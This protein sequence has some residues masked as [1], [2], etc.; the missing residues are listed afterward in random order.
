MTKKVHGLVK[1]V[2]VV[3]LSLL[4]SSGFSKG[5]GQLAPKEVAD[6]TESLREI[7]TFGLGCFWCG[8]AVFEQIEGVE[9]VE[10]G[11][12][13]GEIA[14]PSYREV[15][16]SNTGEAEVVHITFDPQKVGYVDLL[17]LFWK[18]HDPTTLNRQ[19][20]D[21]GSQYRSV[22]FYHNAEQ[23]KLAVSSLKR[24]EEAGIFDD[25]IITEITK[26]KPFYKASKEHQDYYRRNKS[27]PYCRFVIAPKLRKLNLKP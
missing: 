6:Q 17:E 27:Q 13:G 19:G 26:A 5:E 20:S 14:H 9:E 4:T 3:V 7:A 22:I 8:E 16:R 12:M 15:F 11:F 2:C 25:P 18:A 1:M 21:V 24:L 23:K 10:S